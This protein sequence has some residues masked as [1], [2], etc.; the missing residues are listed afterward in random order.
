MRVAPAWTLGVLAGGGSRRL[1]RD[2]AAVP[3]ADSTLLQHCVHRLAPDGVPVIVAT[4][5][6]GPG[7]DQGYPWVPDVLP[8]EGPLSGAAALLY[9]CETPY[10]L[11][12]PCDAPLLP[13]D[14]GDRMLARIPGVDGVATVAGG[15]T[16]PMPTLLTV[17]LAPLF[18]A[19]LEQG[20]RRADAWMDHAAAA[21]V[22][23]E[24]LCPNVPSERA[25]L[26]VNTP[27]DLARASELVAEERAR[28]D[29]ESAP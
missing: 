15:R 23:F 5:P 19:L 13:A 24:E 22:P 8:G 1:G 21:L 9:A 3:F 4:R 26:N 14:I 20:E 10:L 11:L 12:V 27:E 29:P 28:V 6:D 17:D 16:W 25:F 2:K 7:R 18:R